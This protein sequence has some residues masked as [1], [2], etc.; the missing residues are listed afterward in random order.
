M[1]SV[2]FGAMASH[3]EPKL[4]SFTE[5]RCL[6]EDYAANLSPTEPEM[7]SLLEG[8]G[9]VLAE[10]LLADRDFP[11]F[12]RS[13]RDGFAVRASDLLACRRGCAA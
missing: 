10:D 11:P 8:L 5:A 1:S 9:L 12:P 6:V 2:A 7:L 3:P 13:T 4:P